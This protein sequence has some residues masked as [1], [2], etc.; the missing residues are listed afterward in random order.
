MTT[1]EA[2]IQILV[3]KEEIRDISKRYNRYADVADGENFAALWTADGEFDIVGDK[4]YKGA[5]QISFACKA[6][7][8]VVHTAVDS[9]ITVD[10]DKATQSSKLILFYKHPDGQDLDFAL[11]TTIT[12]ELVKRGGKWYFK[13]RQSKTDLPFPIALRKLGL[14]R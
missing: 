13:Y 4:V 12:D 8:Q 5:E 10:G 3:D 6:A 1:L 14:V 7:T 2:Q 11:T 9:E